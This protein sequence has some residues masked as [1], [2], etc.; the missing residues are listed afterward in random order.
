[1]IIGNGLDLLVAQA[2]F[3]FA[4]TVLRA[5]FVARPN[6]FLVLARM[7]EPGH[8]A[9]GEV[10]RIHCPDPGRL[11][12]LLMP[13]AMLYISEAIGTATRQTAYD[14]RFVEH[15]P[16]AEQPG[17]LVS[18]DTRVPNQLVGV[19]LCTGALDLVSAPATVR[20]EVTAPPQVGGQVHSRF[21]FQVTGADGAVC[22]VEVKSVTLVENGLALFPDAP[23]TRGA[24]HV[25]EL[26]QIVR[27]GLGR[28]I[29]LFV[30]QRADA[31]A[32]AAHRQ[33]DPHFAETLARAHEQGVEVYGLACHVTTDTIR[34]ERQIPVRL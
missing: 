15:T 19:A 8:R 33:R 30:I 17:I 23:T 1:M 28:G 32:V 31:A 11:R 26:A 16:S 18:L 4:F 9:E 22:W 27:Y 34:V 5:R 6:R 21:D 7:E 29:V 25:E 3:N 10:V 12:E 2:Q 13:D 24:R 14:L 20:S